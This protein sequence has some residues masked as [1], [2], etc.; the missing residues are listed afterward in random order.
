MVVKTKNDVEMELAAALEALE[1]LEAEHQAD[2]DELA[3]LSAE[4]NDARL[5]V[6]N[7]QARRG[8]FSGMDPA[9]LAAVVGGRQAV[10]ADLRAQ[11]RAL[12]GRR[13]A[14][15][16]AEAQERVKRAQQAVIDDQMVAERPEARRLVRE[17]LDALNAYETATKT[18]IEWKSGLPPSVALDYPPPPRRVS[19]EALHN[20]RQAAFQFLKEN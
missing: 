16:L 11:M 18:Y 10:A 4:L 9:A 20:W 6:I 17:L 1:A 2:D 8:H 19:P 15:E 3:R 13:R 14:V 12:A 5:A 7:S